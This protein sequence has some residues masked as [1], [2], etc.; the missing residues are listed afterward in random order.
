MVISRRV[1]Y[2][3]VLLGGALLAAVAWMRH[4]RL[5][6]WGRA[7]LEFEDSLPDDVLVIPIYPR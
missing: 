1:F 5:V 2:D 4:N 7:P 6:N 3:V